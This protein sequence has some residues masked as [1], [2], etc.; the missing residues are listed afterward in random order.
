MSLS[1]FAASF[2]A[3]KVFSVDISQNM[4]CSWHQMLAVTFCGKRIMKGSCCIDSVHSTFHFNQVTVPDIL[5]SQCHSCTDPRIIMFD[6]QWTFHL[7]ITWVDYFSLRFAHAAFVFIL[8][9]ERGGRVHWVICFWR[10]IQYKE[11]TQMFLSLVNLSIN[12][13]GEIDTL[14]SKYINLLRLNMVI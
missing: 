6:G 5:T 4:I 9:Y 14:E 8:E 12:K 11:N 3:G 13:R 1:Q 7:N 2:M 10:L